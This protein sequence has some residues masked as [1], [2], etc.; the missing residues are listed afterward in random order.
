MFWQMK[1]RNIV[2][3]EREQNSDN[4]LEAIPFCVNER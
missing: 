1:Q 4:L 3:A 2:L